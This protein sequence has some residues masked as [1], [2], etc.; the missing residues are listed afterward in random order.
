MPKFREILRWSVLLF[1][2][3]LLV[4]MVSCGG[5][6]ETTTTPTPTP[7]ITPTPTPTPTP[8]WTLTVYSMVSCYD[9]ECYGGCCPIEVTWD[10]GNETVPAQGNETFD[11]P[12][13][14]TVTLDPLADADTCYFYYGLINEQEFGGDDPAGTPMDIPMDA[15]YEVWVYCGRGY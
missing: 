11:I 2:L 10:G 6:G 13:G 5:G 15:N 7:I 3:I 8:T 14:I 12:Q 9:G 1:A 4:P